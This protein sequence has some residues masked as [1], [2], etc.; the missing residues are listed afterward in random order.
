MWTDLP[1]AKKIGPTFSCMIGDGITV[2]TLCFF[3]PI[4]FFMES[5]T[6][7]SKVEKKI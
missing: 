5:W 4:Y 7:F 1:V 3:N 6:D 2:F